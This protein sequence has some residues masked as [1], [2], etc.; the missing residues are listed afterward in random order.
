MGIAEFAEA[1]KSIISFRKKRRHAATKYNRASSVVLRLR[2]IPLFRP[3]VGCL[4]RADFPIYIARH[5]RVISRVLGLFIET[6]V[7]PPP[8]NCKVPPMLLRSFKLGA[9][10]FV[11]GLLTLGSFARAEDDLWKTNFEKAKAEA[12][13]AKKFLL[14]DFTGSDWCTWCIKLKEEVFSKEAFAKGASKNFVF[15]ELDFPMK[16]K[17]EESLKKQNGELAK[18]YKIQGYPTILM[19]DADGKV[20]AKT[21]YR[22]G[23]PEKYVEHL[24]ELVKSYEVVQAIKK[25]LDKSEGVARVK[26]LDQ[27]VE[28]SDKL[29]PDNEDIKTWAEEIVKL[30][31]EN[32]SGLKPKYEFRVLVMQADALKAEKKAKEAK[33]MYEKALALKDVGNVP[34]QKAYLAMG[35]LCFMSQDFVGIG[36][37]LQKA[38][39]LDP[40]SE[41]GKQCQAI[42]DRFKPAIEAQTQM[43][44]LK[45]K[46]ESAQGIERAK[47]LD[48]MITVAEKA[49]PF[50]KVDP[51]DIDKWQKEIITLDPDDKAGL[52]SK[53]AVKSVVDEATKL[54]FGK[55]AVKGK[56]MLEKVLTKP[57][58]NPE[59][60]QEIYL[61]LGSYYLQ[62]KSFKKGIECL[63]K[64]IDAAPES[65]KAAPCKMMLERAEQLLKV[66]AEE[67]KASADEK[68]GTDKKDSEKKESES[69]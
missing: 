5:C 33:A 20:I 30:D 35:E 65:A 66:Q 41:E 48:E 8:F 24:G 53:Y 1:E 43:A 28:A 63:K 32:K 16:K 23:G 54:L 13:E 17:I 34:K 58:L 12:K 6:C 46:L 45:E 42:Y 29:N 21:G 51:K 15:V 50:A 60:A 44:K 11:V 64:A 2:S 55:D 69:K 67:E 49:G 57:K 39:A 36:D 31:P 22:P 26:L 40:K 4:T 25:T 37:C 47:V 61:R 27:I 14:V 52:N 38:I 10:A 3:S 59:Q 68:A 18:K 62:N 56:E 19:L 7:F 9:V